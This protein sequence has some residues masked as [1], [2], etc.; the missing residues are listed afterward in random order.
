[1]QRMQC[2]RKQL[3]PEKEALIEKEMA[4]HIDQLK[5][6]FEDGIFAG[7]TMENMDETHFTIDMGMAKHSASRATPT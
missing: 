3:S 4:F 6:G 2:G 5:R 1:M 7:V